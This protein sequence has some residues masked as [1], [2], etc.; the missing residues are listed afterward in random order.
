M[1]AP[2]HAI[3]TP[4][5]DELRA[6]VRRF[7]DTEVRPHVDEWEDAGRFPDE[8]FRRCGEL[9][10]LG[11]HYPAEWGGSDGDL[12]AGIVFVEELGR[13]GAAGI[14]MAISVQSD[15]ATPALARFGTDVQRDR[16]LRPAIRGDKI[17]AI[18]ITEPDAGS[19]VASIRTRAIRDADVWRISGTKMFITN[20]TRADFLTLVAQTGPEGTHGGISLF[21]VDT[22]LPGVSVSRHLEKLGMWCSDTAEIALDDV[23]VPHDELIGGEPG[24]GFAQLMWQLQYERLAGA[25]ASVGHAGHVLEETIAYARERK[26]F[27]R[28]LADHQVIA[29]K[30]ADAATELEAAR[31]LLYSTAWRVMHDEYPVAEISMTK[32]YCAQ[33]QN[34]LVDTCL[35]VF[36]GAGYLAETPVS[37][38]FR[39]ARLQRIGGGADEIMNE[40]IAKR[41]LGP[42]GNR[43]SSG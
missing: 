30:L 10:F 1:S 7:V 4:E 18:A 27:G 6:A 31:S 21:I 36:G 11:L 43:R 19:D 3:F 22:K 33:V 37:R 20:G 40:V 24:R 16:W 9:G 28:A 29:H 23:P 8:L 14:A 32:K 39:D 17:G 13:A 35:Q 41:L 25:A 15:M 2:R 38:A 5:H 26:T 12:A 34:R 42:P